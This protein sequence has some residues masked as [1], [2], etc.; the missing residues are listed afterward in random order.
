MKRAI[1][2]IVLSVAILL[3][4]C[5][6][7]T[8]S[9]E[10]SEPSS[11][12]TLSVDDGMFTSRDMEI[13]YDE[14]TC[15][16]IELN[17]DAVSCDSD[18]VTVSDGTVTIA[19]EGTYLLTGTLNDSMIIVDAE[20]SD[21]VQ[22]VLDNVSIAN[23]DGAALYV[24]SA[25]KVVVTTAAD[26]ENTL[27]NGGSYTAID[28]NNIDAV[29]FAKSDLTLNGAGTL[30]IQAAAGHGIVS[31]DDL[32]LTSGT[33][34]ITAASHG[35]SGKDSV[36][37][38]SGTY[39]ITCGKDGIHAENTDDASLGFVYIA[40]GTF[41][42]VAD[43]D[44]IS[45][46]ADQQILNGTFS[47]TAGG[48]SG[49]AATDSFPTE[50]EPSASSSEEDTTSTK[51]IKANG[52]LTIQDGTFTIDSADD[53]IHSNSDIVLSSGTYQITTGD[54]GVHADGAVQITG[55][56]LAIA[57]SYEGIEGLTVEISGGEISIVSSDDGLNAVG[58]TDGSGTGS[59]GDSFSANAD[60]W[61]TISGGVISIDAEG[62]GIDSNGSLTVS[63]GEIYVYGPERSGNGALDYNGEASITGGLVVAFGPSG[64]AQNFGTSSTQ[65]AMLVSISGSAGDTVTLTA[66]DGTVLVS[67]QSQKAYSSVVISCPELVQGETYTLNA[68]GTSTQITMDSLIYGETGGFGG[69]RGGMMP[70]GTAP[71]G[72]PPDGTAPNTA[73]DAM[74]GGQRQPA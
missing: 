10:I 74:R 61:I 67:C 31:K 7:T 48:G 45:S 35:L 34:R 56:T 6:Q 72:T 69:G 14:S 15:V 55:G 21:D 11:G 20:D 59:R 37:I 50:A 57:Q 23:E 18:A 30:N 38:A 62:D 36:R 66:S 22:L 51:G 4:G 3:T 54:D 47:I 41:S 16:H 68:G 42:I 28:D 2:A 49:E 64:M 65:G 60:A 63:G 33:Y 39:T 46:G 53:A 71:N 40:D 8:A 5:S 29:V 17:G 1:A 32:A 70:D 12:A 43:G 19:D 52:N 27:S 44:G 13:G 58:G 73:P 25:D 24:R 26:S 9:S